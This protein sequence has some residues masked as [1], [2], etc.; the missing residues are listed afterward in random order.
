MIRSYNFKQPVHYLANSL[1]MA[2]PVLSFKNCFQ[3]SKIIMFKIICAIWIDLVYSRKKQNINA[4]FFKQV[5]IFFNGDRVSL[6][7]FWIVEL[8]GVDK[9]TANRNSYVL[10]RFV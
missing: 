3:I 6:K 8:G 1:E 10:L 2:G 5:D 4:A 9:N 7:I